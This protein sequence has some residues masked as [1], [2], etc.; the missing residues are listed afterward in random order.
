MADVAERLLEEVEEISEQ[1]L[2][3]GLWHVPGD[4][5]VALEDLT[6]RAAA[7][8]LSAGAER[9]GRLRAAL[10]SPDA[11]WGAL[12]ELL[13][14]S[15]L[16]RRAAALARVEADL[17]RGAEAAAAA[18]PAGGYDGRVCFHGFDLDEAGRLV[19]HGVEVD[20]GEE[21][22]VL[23]RLSEHEPEDPFRGRVISRLLQAAVPLRDLVDGL[24]CFDGHP[25]QRRRRRVELA[26]AFREVPTLRHLDASFARPPA[27]TVEARLDAAGD[28]FTPAGTLTETPTLRLNLTKLRWYEPDAVTRVAVRRRGE[29]L[30]VLHAWDAVGDRVFPAQDPAALRAPSAAR[31]AVDV[32]PFPLPEGDPD[33]QREFLLAHLEDLRRPQTPLPE[34]RTLLALA[35]ALAR[36][37]DLPETGAVARLELSKLRVARTCAAA[38]ARGDDA[39]HALACLESAGVAGWFVR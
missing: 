35:H 17:A 34:P 26:P 11:A 7:L 25:F 22:R 19:L 23:D 31:P 27:E 6:A 18:R 38:L 28:W 30:D 2:V 9:L 24:L 36:L 21:V 1:I 8:G 20:T 39:G 5:G 37:E 15:R 12:Q 16:F 3:C 4:L 14:W 10:V 13:A 29:T 32:E 33:R